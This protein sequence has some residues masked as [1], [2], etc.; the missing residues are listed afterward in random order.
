MNQDPHI[1]LID[2]G[3]RYRRRGNILKRSSYYQALQGVNLE[4]NPGETLGI[5]GRNG[6]GKSTLLRVISGIL[7]P[8]SGRV[9]NN[10]CTVSLLALQ[11]GFD[12]VLNGRE[13]AVLSGMLQ[14]VSRRDMHRKLDEI[15]DYAE[16][17]EFFDE[18]VR[19][20]STGMR[21]RLGFAI[22]TITRPD[23]LL[24]DEVLSVGDQEFRKKSERTIAQKIRS[25]QTVLLV[26]HSIPQAELLC[27]RIVTISEGTIMPYV[28]KDS[29][30]RPSQR[31]SQPT[32]AGNAE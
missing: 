6:A 28:S 17:G 31:S 16:L 5:L 13:N 21:A 7:K 29:S 14:G 26:T 11:A 2:V 24:I 27:N 19:T 3:V 22:A 4:I 12:P 30:K 20:Y 18:P 32:L 9:I 8:D 10:N 23:V 1:S 15:N 25:G